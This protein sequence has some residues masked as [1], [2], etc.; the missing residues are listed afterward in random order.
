MNHRL[1][2]LVRFY[3]L[4]FLIFTLI[5][6]TGCSHQPK[7][8]VNIRMVNAKK[9]MAYLV[10]LDNTQD[11]IIDSAKFNRN[12]KINLSVVGDVP[13]YYQIRFENDQ[14]LTLVLSPNEKVKLS[15]DYNNI[16]KTKQIE[17]SDNSIKVNLLNDSLRNTLSRL[18]IIRREYAKLAET[19]HD[20][21]KFK[22]LSDK[23]LDIL[24]MHKKFSIRFILND[25]KSLANI[26]VLFQEYSPGYYVFSEGRDIQ[27][28]KLVS[29]SLSKYYPNVKY[30]KILSDNYKA[31]FEDYQKQ[32]IM[33]MIKPGDNI[34]P[35]II[36]P[37]KSGS[38]TKLSSLR[39]KI[40]L[41]SFWSIKDDNCVVFN[42]GMIPI[43]KKYRRN[44]FE[45]YQ[46]SIDHSREEWLQAIKYDEIP[47]ISV[48]D[49]TFPNSN[50]QWAYNLS[51]IPLNYL[52]SKDQVEIIG[53][54]LTPVVLDQQLSQLLKK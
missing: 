6:I 17:G 43:Y 10:E 44:N 53:K 2:K 46:V 16:Y 52:I 22:R 48:S 11:Q 27:F 4:G 30:V 54:N 50:I 51:S 24:A 32:R 29:D 14:S 19:D 9:T 1:A 7:A 20:S 49:T 47:W 28:Y 23:Y 37:D 34:L 8:I 42:R 31:M 35:D 38:I 25:L 40:V 18:D 26:A 45:I 39:G 12:G 41:L 5:I 15:A 21:S 36:L 3:N 13:G 33:K